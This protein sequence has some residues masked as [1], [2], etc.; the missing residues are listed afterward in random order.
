MS[1]Y[2]I[3]K[4]CP[5]CAGTAFKR[6]KSEEFIAFGS[7]RICD[8]CQTR[9]T[10][11]TPVWA[12]IVFILIGLLM[13]LFGGYAIFTRLTRGNIIGIPAM[14]IEGFIG[15]LGLLA[16]GHGLHVLVRPGKV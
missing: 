5:Q 10:P 6:K 13:A 4:V 9:Y 1:K 8:A 15:F 12:A 3:S 16:I 7:D 2:P 14:I 11:P